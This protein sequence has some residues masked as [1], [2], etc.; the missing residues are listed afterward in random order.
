MMG[1]ILKDLLTISR[2]RIYFIMIIGFALIPDSFLSNFVIIFAAMLPIT[3][4]AYD[5]RSKWTELQS[6]MPYSDKEVIYSKYILGYSIIAAVT[7]LSYILHLILSLFIVEYKALI[8]PSIIMLILGVA[9]IISAINMPIMF[10]FGVEKGR[11]AFIGLMALTTMLG[12]NISIL[13][14]TIFE[15]THIEFI[16]IGIAIIINILSIMISSKINLKL[17][18]N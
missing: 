13:D 17:G 2:H 15:N 9:L 3:A 6:M 4:I 8:D 14:V 18:G 10:K 11:F 5:E 16:I 12:T 1:L 7:V